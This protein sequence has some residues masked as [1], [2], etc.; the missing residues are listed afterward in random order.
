MADNRTYRLK[1]ILMISALAIGLA[2]MPQVYHNL[3]FDNLKTE[4]IR[5]VKG[6]SQN[7]VNC[8]IQDRDGYLWF[9]TWDGLNQYDAY[10]FRIFRKKDGMSNPTINTILEDEQGIIWIGTQDGLNRYDRKTRTFEVHKHDPGNSNSISNNTINHLFLDH[11]GYLWISTLQG[12][13]RY[14]KERHV[15]T[16]YHFNIS[17]TDSIRSNWINRVAGDHNGK[18]WIGTRYGLFNF[19]DS[20][21]LFTPYFHDPADLSSLSSNDVNEIYLDRAGNLWVGTQ[22]GLNLFRGR[23]KGFERYLHNRDDRQSISNNVIRAVFEDS[24]GVLWIGTRNKLNLFDRENGRFIRYGHTGESNSISNDEINCIYEDDMGAVWIGTYKGVNRVDRGVSKFRSYRRDPDEAG[25][26]TSNI[27][28]SIFRDRQGLIW[29]GTGKGVNIYDPGT[30][31]YSQLNYPITPHT[32]LRDERISS[33]HYDSRGR[34]W[35]GT[36]SHGLFGYDPATGGMK[37]Y[38]ARA[39]HQGLLNSNNILC[40]FEDHQGYFWIGSNRGLNRFHPDSSSGKSWMHDPRN[41][42]SIS[43]NQVWT[44]YQDSRN[45]IWLGTDNGLNRYLPSEDR[46][47]S[48]TSQPDNPASISA[49]AVY[50]IYEDSRGRYWIGTMG[51]GLNRFDPE[52]ETFIQYTENDGMPNNVVYITLEDANGNLWLTTNWGLSKFDPETE[53]FVN[54]DVSD[55]LQGNEFNGGAWF[56]AD[57]GEMF[58][59]GMDG[60]NSFF[61]D[62]IVSNEIP[63]RLVITYF[64]KLNRELLRSFDD[65]DTITLNY[66]DNFFSIGF[67]ALDYSNPSKNKY[68]YKLENYD[69]DW[70]FRDAD[71]RYAEYTRVKPGAYI[72][73]VIGSNND[74]VWNEEGISLHIHILPPWWETMLFRILSALFIITAFWLFV[75][76]RIRAVKKKHR[77]EKRMLEIERQLF[78]VQQKAL[79]LQMNPHF[80]FNSLNAIQSFVISNDTDK[81]IHYL[82]KFSQLMRLV[83]ANS[84]EIS[85]PVKDELKAV[86]HYLDIERL[87]FDNKF[88]YRLEIDKN[89]DQD[90]MEIP[91][92]ILQP[93]VENAILHGLIHSER[94]GMIN[95]EMKLEEEFIF[96]SIQDNGIGREKAREIRDASG[97]KKESRGMLITRE[98][99]EILN[100]QGRDKFAVKVIDLI[101]KDGTPAGTRVEINIF[102]IDE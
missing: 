3:R 16:R 9:G 62:E 100:K 40:I 21:R 50:G 60:F 46:F 94:P 56:L 54:Y 1:G 92:M 7:M 30:G 31:K 43:S 11:H 49:N 84:R 13:N 85:I 75:Y 67:S 63:P 64:K 55:G 15:F 53:E 91:P 18:L 2:A 98:R 65:G 41:P 52:T 34:V 51:G 48:Y 24:R 61:P 12:L 26:L 33:M 68:R 59:G 45:N 89:I 14:D 6:L 73:R 82:S 17:E 19:D 90:F 29:L 77:V 58:F 8:I 97:L 44:I 70:I 25:S 86:I 83:L 38:R 37:I 22:N 78:D 93:F 69:E 27:I 95:I 74:G 28:H 10:D 47:V 101:E 81:A 76:W 5:H 39:S 42:G 71:R 88:D 66:D 79:Q 80:I 32:D 87:R 4:N 57:N 72:F 35:I 102:Y 36:D 23:G 96:C 99:L 20:T